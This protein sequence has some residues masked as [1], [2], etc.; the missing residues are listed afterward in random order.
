M[1]ARKADN[2][3]KKKER[4]ANFH[5]EILR[6]LRFR[7]IRISDYPCMLFIFFVG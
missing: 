2:S 4:K 5:L 7:Q 3:K 1:V 6:Y